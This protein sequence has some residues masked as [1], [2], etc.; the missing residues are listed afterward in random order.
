MKRSQPIAI[1]GVG[2]VFPDAPDLDR[3]WANIAEGRCSAREVP[4]GRWLLSKADAFDPEGAKK[5]LASIKVGA[6]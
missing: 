3:F 2:G 1:V 5:L 6:K 4:E